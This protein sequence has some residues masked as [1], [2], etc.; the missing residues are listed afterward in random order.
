MK[1]LCQ[2]PIC[3]L[4]FSGRWSEQRELASRELTLLILSDSYI[5]D[6]PPNSQAPLLQYSKYLGGKNL[7]HKRLVT[8]IIQKYMGYMFSITGGFRYQ[9]ILLGFAEKCFMMLLCF[10]LISQQL[11]VAAGKIPMTTSS[12]LNRL[13]WGVNGLNRLFLCLCV[14]LIQIILLRNALKSV[15]LIQN[16][17]KPF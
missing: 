11:L 15:E 1:F 2:F 13:S 17:N 12:V 5:L 8:A 4:A 10:Q 16:N 6:H 14:N 3:L 9:I 7:F